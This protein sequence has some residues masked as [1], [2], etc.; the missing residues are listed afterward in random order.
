MVVVVVVAR[1]GKGAAAF[2]DSARTTLS[3]FPAFFS[4]VPLSALSRSRVFFFGFF[5][6]DFAVCRVWSSASKVKSQ[7][8][9]AQR[10]QKPEDPR[11][12]PI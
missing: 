10:T 1:K 3:F 12:Q 9:K 6:R 4:S 11:T 5:F 8:L 7:K 2:V